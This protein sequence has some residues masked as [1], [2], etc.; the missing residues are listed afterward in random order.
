MTIILLVLTML[1]IASLVVL[2]GLYRRMNVLKRD[3]SGTTSQAIRRIGRAISTF[4]SGDLRIRARKPDTEPV[5]PEGASL[6]KLL[7]TVVSDFNSITDVPSKRICFTGAN[8]YQEGKLAGEKI[9]AILGGKGNVACMIPYYT[10]VNHVLRMKGCLDYLSENHPGIHSLG[11][12]EGEGNRDRAMV[13]CDTILAQHAQIDLIY[14]TDGHT[15]PSV[16]EELQIKKRGNIRVAAFDAMPENIALLKS[17]RISCLIEQNSFAQSYNAVVH[18]YNAC[19]TSWQPL[20][21]K[22]FMEPIGIDMSNYLT[23]WDDRENKRI[24]KDYE[25]AQLAVPERNKSGK[26]YKFALILPHSLGFFEGL[27]KGA[28]A[29]KTLMRDYNAEVEIV[30][31]FKGWSDFG[32]A[33]LFVPLIERFVK[34]R[35]DGIATVVVDPAIVPAIN[36]AVKAGLVVSTFNTEP[37]SFREIIMN[38]I[39]NMEQLSDNSQTLAAAAEES[40]RANSQIS[41]AINGIQQNIS[42]QKQRIDSSDTELQGLNRMISEVQTAI[43]R[44]SSLVE[45]MNNESREGMQAVDIT[46][47]EIKRLKETIDRIAIELD[48]FSG[49][50]T[51]VQEFAGVIENL[52][53]STNVLAINA[54]IQAARAGVAGK[55]FAVVAGEVR[56]LA[57]NSRHTAEGIREIVNEISGDMKKVVSASSEGT[58][59]VSGTLD[60]AQHARKAFEEINQVLQ[61]ANESI[62]GIGHSVGGIVS[63]GDLVKKNM[64]AIETMSSTSVSRLEEINVS[65]K[66][67]EIQG[68]HLSKTA[69]DLRIMAENQQIVFSQLSVK[70]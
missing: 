58:S 42:E 43:S 3:I 2:Y 66:E 46:W 39:G 62:N 8:S 24:L 56:S 36:K 4:S 6:K 40:S 30:D 47:E 28:E 19:E 57:E 17:G 33:S 59:R 70:E 41:H 12:Y 18:L 37:S 69:N 50:L 15:P 48:A 67:L 63:A 22:L 1:L 9:A 44:Y 54:S 5:T 60:Q 29:V 34:E 65:V 35:F 16:V 52:A 53:E 21:P 11:V 14:I 25:V 13:V 55:S 32:S 20:S 31:A 27:G 51:R 45:R 61:D 38:M 68:A 26:K 49:K 10:Q 7:E 64:D 23:Y